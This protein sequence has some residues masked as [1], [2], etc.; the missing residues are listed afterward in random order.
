MSGNNDNGAA[1]GPTPSRPHPRSDSKSDGTSGSGVA[2]WLPWRGWDGERLIEQFYVTLDAQ[3]SQIRDRNPAGDEDAERIAEIECLLAKEPKT[4][5]GAYQIE[6]LLVPLYSDVELDREIRRRLVDAKEMLRPNTLAMCENQWEA[7]QQP[8][9]AGQREEK[10]ALLSRLVNDLQWRYE[11]R[12]A[13]RD[14]GTTATFRTSLVFTFGAALFL[15]AVYLYHTLDFAVPDHLFTALASGFLGAGFSMMMNLQSRIRGGTFDDLKQ[16]SSW[17][18]ILLRSFI[19]LGA[20]LVLDYFLVA[21]LLSGDLLPEIDAES[22]EIIGHADHAKFV[23][24]CFLAGFSERL[25]PSLLASTAE[26]AKD[27]QPD[28]ST[29]SASGNDGR[30]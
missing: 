6:Q 3:F 30:T 15:G 18:H 10:V 22:G 14:A 7:I 11:I 1:Q 19:G 13:A 12:Q 20:A 21:G 26:R 8:D 25:V 24:W 16:L 17:S 23:V 2:S 29:E 5:R 4:W 27:V 28:E 9:G